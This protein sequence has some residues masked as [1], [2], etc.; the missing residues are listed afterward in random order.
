[1]QVAA[2]PY[3]FL[4]SPVECPYRCY[5]REIETRIPGLS[6]R[7]T[8]AHMANGATYQIAMFRRQDKKP[9]AFVVK[10]APF[11]KKK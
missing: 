5:T 11:V 4:E 6:E 7:M 1:L 8:F 3:L 10:V 9:I 2:P